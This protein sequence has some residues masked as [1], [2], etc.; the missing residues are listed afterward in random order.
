MKY[1]VVIPVFNSEK[2]IGTIIDELVIFFKERKLDFEI[3]LV[4]DGS[5]DLSWSIINKKILEYPKKNMTLF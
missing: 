4:N 3:V 1:S 5:K 2:T